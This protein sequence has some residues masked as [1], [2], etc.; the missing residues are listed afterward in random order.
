MDLER[1]NE[2][3]F[4]KISKWKTLV[5]IVSF[6][7][8]WNLLIA[9]QSYGVFLMCLTTLSFRIFNNKLVIMHYIFDI[10]YVFEIIF[11]LA[12][13]RNREY[14]KLKHSLGRKWFFIVIDIISVIP[15]EIFYFVHYITATPN[16]DIIRALLQNRLL[17][18]YRIFQLENLYGITVR[19]PIQYMLFMFIMFISKAILIFHVLC[20]IWVNLPHSVSCDDT[21][22]ICFFWYEVNMANLVVLN[23]GGPK[24]LLTGDWEYFL[25]LVGIFLGVILIYAYFFPFVFL[26]SVQLK[27]S[28]V[29]YYDRYK[30]M[31]RF[32]DNMIDKEEVRKRVL[33]NCIDAW[34]STIDLKPLLENIPLALKKEIFTDIYWDA[35]RHSELLRTVTRNCKRSLSLVMTTN[36]YHSG[37]IIYLKGQMKEKMLFL[38]QGT[39]QIMAEENEKSPLLSFSSGTVFG[40]SSLFL[41]T[42]SQAI[43]KCK[44][45]CEFQI[46]TVAAAMEV[47]K[48]YPQDKKLIYQRL[49]QRIVMAKYT[50]WRKN[51]F[52]LKDQNMFAGE[53][54]IEDCVKWIKTQWSTVWESHKR[55]RLIIKAMEEGHR[56]PSF[57]RTT[58]P[59]IKIEFISNYLEL[60]VLS[61]A[62]EE[63]KDAV[64]LR[65]EFPWSIDPG[66]SFF[67]LWYAVV[68]V[69]SF[70]PIIFYPACTAWLEEFPR[71]VYV[72][73]FLISGVFQVD[74]ILRF[75]TA[76]KTKHYILTQF[77]AVLIHRLKEPTFYLDII[78]AIPYQ[79]YIMLHLKEMQPYE[80]GLFLHPAILKFHVFVTL[81]V[82]F[83][84]HMAKWTFAKY[85]VVFIFLLYLFSE[86][87]QLFYVKNE[88][89][90]RDVDNWMNRFLKDRENDLVRAHLLSVIRALMSAIGIPDHY[91]YP[92]GTPSLILECLSKYFFFFFFCILLGDFYGSYIISI[93][94]QETFLV[95]L[96]RI[97]KFLG[98]VNLPKQIAGR[99]LRTVKFQWKY[100]NADYLSSA[101]PITK[102]TPYDLINQIYTE[103]AY[104]TLQSCHLFENESMECLIAVMEL[105]FIVAVPA[106]SLLVSYGHTSH[107]VS[108]IHRGTCQI[109][110]FLAND[111]NAGLG[112]PILVSTGSSF[113]LLSSLCNVPAPV[114]VVSLTDCEVIM[115]HL[116]DLVQ[117]LINF[118]I[119]KDVLDVLKEKKFLE[120]LRN[121]K[122]GLIGV[123]N[124]IYNTELAKNHG[125]TRR[126][127]LKHFFSH[128]FNLCFRGSQFSINMKF[129]K[130]WE[131]VYSLYLVLICIVWPNCF[132]IFAYSSHILIPT[133]I[134]SKVMFLFNIFFSARTPYYNKLGLL[135]THPHYTILNY[136]SSTL[137]LELFCFL[138][139]FS[140]YNYIISDPMEKLP[141]WVVLF[142]FLQ[143]FLKASHILGYLDNLESVLNSKYAI[144]MVKTML[145]LFIALNFFI[146]FVMFQMAD[147]V[148]DAPH[149][150]VA[151]ELPDKYGPENR[152]LLQKNSLADYYL[153]ISYWILCNLNTVDCHL[154]HPKDTELY[155]GYVFNVIGTIL[156]YY[157]FC[158]I[159][160]NSFFTYLGEIIFQ[161]KIASFVK[162]LEREDA[163]EKLVEHILSYYTYEWSKTRGE[164]L[165]VTFERLPT[166][167]HEELVYPMYRSTLSR[168]EVFANADEGFYKI[169]SKHLTTVYFNRGS[170]II[171][172]NE[173][174]S[175]LY[176]LH[177]G[178]CFVYDWFV[179]LEHGSLIG[180]I[181]RTGLMKN[182]IYALTHVEMLKISADDF[183]M[184][185][186]C[187]EELETSFFKS[188]ENLE[189]FFKCH[190]SNEGY[191]LHPVDSMD[192]LHAFG[193]QRKVIGFED[194]SYFEE[195]DKSSILMRKTMKFKAD[196]KRR[197][198]T[199][200]PNSWKMKAFGYMIQCNA[201]FT[202]III[203][204]LSS[205]GTLTVEAF[206]IVG[207]LDVL[208]LITIGLSFRVGYIDKVKGDVV[209]DFKFVAKKYI[210]RWDGFVIDVIACIPF[211]GFYLLAFDSVKK[212]NPSVVSWLRVFRL[213]RGCYLLKNIKLESQKLNTNHYLIYLH[214]VL[215]MIIWLFLFGNLVIL[216]GNT[217]EFSSKKDPYKISLDQ[218]FLFVKSNLYVVS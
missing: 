200:Y 113:P 195:T 208:W 18:I 33:E 7:K 162:Y 136:V 145:L 161:E 70:L 154:N 47:L 75:F 46:L 72:A 144:R 125:K 176:F 188:I 131:A 206:V 155:A 109:S 35:F 37:E 59:D 30:K 96:K 191:Q 9:V 61:D 24:E 164:N 10:F 124:N 27:Y 100:D 94:S 214:V 175:D 107:M 181:R 207:I 51:E 57:H 101:T 29:L 111:T 104:K 99:L 4:E 76:V 91:M 187:F 137:F 177:N 2:L 151:Y 168:I 150:I 6:S 14:I 170:V 184:I 213:L 130:K 78:A 25:V 3:G 121:V 60:L 50:Q 95:L 166:H 146:N 182:K 97:M 71:S 44:S 77:S 83:S 205:F 193:L 148:Y 89:Q 21:R 204:L 147:W 38:I 202:S 134:G 117:I 48:D 179:I 165:K 171:F 62:L 149:R 43:V 84:N 45:Y 160:S 128:A 63:K 1:I 69:T 23:W 163:D 42:P 133:L 116:D 20:C 192:V 54:N 112:W 58:K 86:G 198:F 52:L 212:A 82:R 19:K 102:C 174:Q 217:E 93:F 56:I 32:L 135:V 201:F 49:K 115:I 196:E 5:L 68:M 16:M 53:S 106:G 172:Q 167:L 65:T 34:Q 80:I 156:Q 98:S 90:G 64:C 158:W 26:V 215:H 55:Q 126:H 85:S 12:Y 139:V 132:G 183:F 142:S 140:V 120:K 74:L 123:R 141:V 185:I 8:W 40:E 169:L 22:Y 159:A 186:N 218:F 88:K 189:N 152:D 129:I 28:R 210:K 105:S 216:L 39:A 15:L 92:D 122:P 73:S 203:P 87:I 138:P 178:K 209:T 31:V 81:R 119:F 13:R 199:I 127:S 79:I 153:F 108:I 211:E 157:L 103:S 11:T 67:K 36:N 41:H 17:R 173:V 180:D 190:I 197:L 143:H 110:S 66:A 118:N 194:E 114:A